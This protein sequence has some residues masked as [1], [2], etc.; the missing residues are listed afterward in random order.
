MLGEVSVRPAIAADARAI[1]EIHVET[2]RVAYRGHM[3]DAY[4]ASL[5]VDQRATMWR[6]R[7][8]TKGHPSR[9]IWVAV[10]DGRVIGFAVTGDTRDTYA[11]GERVGEL[12]AI[13]V[14]AD[15]W[16][17]G[18]GRRL[19]ERAVTDMAQQG[20]D[21]A[22]LWVLEVNERTRRF[23]VANGWRADGANKVESVGGVDLV[24]VRYRYELALPA[25]S[26]P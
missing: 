7:L 2:W 4:L 21:A 11:A 13:Y 10:M 15:R 19:I 9:C 26:H 16:G 20:Y 1:G 17:V 18:A 23:Y 5:S 8:E 3:P 22:T 6:E 14:A 12:Y 24:H 25:K